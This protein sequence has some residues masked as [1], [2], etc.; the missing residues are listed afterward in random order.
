MR[1]ALFPLNAVLFP[2]GLLPL[3]VFEAR[4]MDMV[5]DCLRS[6]QPF[7]VNLITEGQEVGQAAHC[8]AVGC[9]ATIEDWDMEQFGVLQIRCRGGA[10]FRTLSRTVE[11]GGLV[12][13]EVEHIADDQDRPLAPEHAPCASLLR[14]IVEDRNAQAAAAG[15]A[16]APPALPFTPPYRFESTVWVGNRLCEVLPVPLRAKQ[17]LMALEDAEARLA[18]VS[19]YLKQHS[20]L[21]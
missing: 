17:K 8:E 1:I 13:A 5:R 14:R 4:Y 18:I 6:G 15:P 9:L 20:V 12:R 11:P 10:R 3:R 21:K 16:D 7:G 2:G 19:R